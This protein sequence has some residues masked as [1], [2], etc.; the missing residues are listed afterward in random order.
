M[1]LQWMFH[2]Y[3]SGRGIYTARRLGEEADED[4]FPLFSAF[5]EGIR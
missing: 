4:W 5:F 3:F 1:E 2:E